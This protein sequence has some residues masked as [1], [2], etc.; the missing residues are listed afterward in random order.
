MLNGL[1]AALAALTDRCY[2]FTARPNTAPPYLVWSEDGDNDLSSDDV[3][4]C[5]AYQCSIDLYT[6]AE[7]DPL[8]AKVPQALETL[9]ASYY[10]NSVQ[11]EEETELIHYEWIAEVVENG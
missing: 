10:L 4:A 8:M 6:R 9:G 5:R 7:N 1:R 2:H 3:H 11:F